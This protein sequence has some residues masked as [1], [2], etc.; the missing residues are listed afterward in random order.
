MQL[1]F[2]SD[3]RTEQP[4]YVLDTN[5][6][7]H[8]VQVLRMKEGAVLELTNGKGLSGRAVITQADKR[9]CQVAI[10]HFDTHTPPDHHLTIAV[11]FTK[12]KSRNEWMLEKMTEIGVQTIIPIVTQRTEK[13]KFNFDRIAAIVTAAMLQSRQ[14]FMPGIQ[15]P[16]SIQKIDYPMYAQKFVA[17][18]EEDTDKKYLESAL[19]AAT[20]TLIMIGP[21]GDF[22]PDEIT[23]LKEQGV[24]AVSLGKRRLRTETAAIYAATVFNAKNDA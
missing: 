20:D 4:T 16:V 17:H 6:S 21:E 22:T 1:Y 5:T 11:S 18:C 7:R 9:N 8:L 3:L 14:Y 19:T 15:E 10:E 12:N 13:E 2:L 24:W 23:Y